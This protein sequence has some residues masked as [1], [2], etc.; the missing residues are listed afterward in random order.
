MLALGLNSGS[1]FDGIDAVLVDIEIGEDGLLKRPRFIAGKTVEWP[2]RIAD[3]VLAAFENKLSIFEL[4]RLNYVAGALYA[5]AARSLMRETR[6]TPEALAVI[7]FDGQTIYQEPADQSRMAQFAAS[8]DLVGRWLDGPYPCGLQIA[9]PAIV[10][11]ACDATVVTQ[12]RPV[13]H[14]LG[15][16]GAPLMQF[17]DFVAFRDIG[18]ILTLNI[19]GIAN[20]QLADADRRRMMAFDTGPGNVMLDHAARVLL[21]KPHDADGAAAARGKVQQTMLSRLLE[22]DFFHRKPPR[23]AWRLDFGSAFAERH[24]AENRNL[25]PEDLL[26]TFTEFTA[27]SVA[28]SI[29]DHIQI[30]SEITTLIASGGGVRNKALMERLRANLPSGL[31]LTVSDDYG[32]PAQYKEAIKFAALALAAQLRLANNIPAASGASRF[33]ILGKL[34]AAPGLA[35]GTGLS[36]E[37]I[38]P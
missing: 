21:G 4:C 23:S 25:S 34:V 35:R 13:K 5:Q 26:A 10:A 17:L 16:S 32:I 37:A 12:F 14:A 22:H 20:C 24:I 33:A 28:R 15:G 9:E 18:P 6:T 3:Q 19:G 27:V 38:L 36:H 29:C 7:G 30:L 31:R 8:E 11:A 2:Q 1:S